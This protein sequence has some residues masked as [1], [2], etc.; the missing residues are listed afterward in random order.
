MHEWTHKHRLQQ[1]WS[2]PPQGYAPLGC[3]RTLAR[4]PL[5]VAQLTSIISAITTPHTPI[6]E[7]AVWRGHRLREACL[8]VGGGLLCRYLRTRRHE[9]RSKDCSRN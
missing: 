9:N 3:R 4:A 7:F 2:S 5:R 6:D 8:Y 1:Y